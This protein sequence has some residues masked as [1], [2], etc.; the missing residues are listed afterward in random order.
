MAVEISQHHCSI[1][2][3]ADGQFCNIYAPLQLLA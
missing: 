3:E 1:C 2:Q